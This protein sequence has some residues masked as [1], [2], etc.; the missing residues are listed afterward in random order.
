M[1]S[2]MEKLAFGKTNHHSTRL[3]FGAAALAA[4]TQHEADRAMEHVMEYGINHIDTAASYGESEL[5]LG[6]WLKKY[7]KDFFLAT[8]TEMRSRKEAKEELY[9]SLERLQT[10]S[11]DL[12]Q[13]HVLIRENEW[14]TAMAVDGAI[15]AFIEARDEGL[16]RFL[17]VTGHELIAPNIHMR[18]LDRHDFD[19][20]LLPYNYVLMENENY[21]NDF[22]TLYNRCMKENIAFQCIKTVCRRPWGIDRQNRATWY[23]P[24]EDQPSIDTAVG[25]ALSLKNVFLNTAGDI[26]ILPMML[27][28][29]KNFDP[30]YDYSKDMARLAQESGMTSLF[31]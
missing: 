5:R 17:G 12:W 24:F 3:L 25:W 11:V 23:Q 26:H 2:S 21:R 4:V 29:G 7:R 20:V 15:E 18:S 14:K 13:M 31:T 8:K 28:A 6:P 16:V 30:A 9:R 19:S 10:D 1:R 22:E 27:E